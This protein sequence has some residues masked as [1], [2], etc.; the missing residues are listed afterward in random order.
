MS[1]YD[2]TSGLTPDEKAVMD[3]LVAARNAFYNLDRGYPP[4]DQRAFQDGIHMCQQVLASWALHR[5]YPEYWR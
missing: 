2:L 4:E 3:A 5:A 1:D